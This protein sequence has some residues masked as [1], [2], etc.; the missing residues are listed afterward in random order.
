[1]SVCC[2]GGSTLTDLCSLFVMQFL[3]SHFV[4]LVQFGFFQVCPRP[5]CMRQFSH[6]HTQ[7]TSLLFV[8][9][10]TR[11]CIAFIPEGS[12]DFLLNSQLVLEPSSLTR[13]PVAVHFC[14]SPFESMHHKGPIGP[15][16]AKRRFLR[17][18]FFVLC[19]AILGFGAAN[20]TVALLATSEATSRCT[21]LLS[22]LPPSNAAHCSP[23]A[24]PQ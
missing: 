14:A 24:A 6:V 19:L 22:V 15:G 4:L 5:A 2:C 11:R 12:S 1:M 10:A 18:S 17:L 3:N 13:R 20:Q 21:F 9:R 23:P 7:C 16:A 8:L